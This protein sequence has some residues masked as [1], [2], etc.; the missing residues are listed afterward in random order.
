MDVSPVIKQVLHRLQV[1]MAAGC[2]EGRVPT[3][4]VLNIQVGW[5]FFQEVIQLIDVAF[6]RYLTRWLRRKRRKT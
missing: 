6:V 1:S 3:V 4:V 2:N 5:I